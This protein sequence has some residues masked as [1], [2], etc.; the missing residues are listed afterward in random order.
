MKISHITT[1]KAQFFDVDSMDVVWHGNYVKYLEIA[2]CELLSKIG[3]DYKKM[4]TDG[5]AYPIVKLNVKYIKPIF[6]GDEIEIETILVEFES[7]LKF[8]YIIKNRSTKAKLS[9]ANTSQVAV[10]MRTMQTCF[11]LP[12]E[13]KNA[14]KRHENETNDPAC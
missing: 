4:K 6:F 7:F 1:I 9:E 11:F 13:I 2:R 3:Y 5:F 8:H 12:E 14:I 10:D